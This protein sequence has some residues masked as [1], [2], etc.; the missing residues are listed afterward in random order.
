MVDEFDAACAARQRALMLPVRILNGRRHPPR[1]RA[2]EIPEIDV[3]RVV[4]PLVMC[5]D[6][7]KSMQ[8]ANEPL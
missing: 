3:L 2:A 7:L 1:P 8:V 4:N 6:Y 5:D